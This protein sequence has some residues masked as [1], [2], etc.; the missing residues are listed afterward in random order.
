M[1][2]AAKNQVGKWPNTAA[3]ATAWRCSRVILPFG[4][5]RR[6]RTLATRLLVGHG[7]TLPRQMVRPRAQVWPHPAEDDRVQPAVVDR[8]VELVLIEIGVREQD[9]GNAR[10]QL[11]RRAVDQRGALAL[12]LEGAL[13]AQSGGL[14]RARQ[15]AALRP[16]SGLALAR[17]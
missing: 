10:G 16:G 7:S 4:F 5:S 2:R 13:V 8:G 9:A 14:M 11:D 1:S 17:P 3:F 6:C 12:A 15:P